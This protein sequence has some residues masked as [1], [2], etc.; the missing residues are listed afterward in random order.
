MNLIN[1]TV[2][3]TSLTQHPLNPRIHGKENINYIKKSLKTFNQYSPIIVDKE[4]QT[5]LAGNGT[6]QAAIE[7]GFTEIDTVQIEGL[8]EEQKNAIIIADNK[9]NE[10]SYWFKDSF[11]EMSCDFELLNEDFE[12]FIQKI[13]PHKKEKQDNLKN[14][15]KQLCPFCHSDKKIK[16]LEVDKSKIVYLNKSSSLPSAS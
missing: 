14:K 8:T 15:S 11:K 4:N 16:I 1:L 5:I 6:F 12:K 2:P 3:V 10:S 13:F 9:L 7:L